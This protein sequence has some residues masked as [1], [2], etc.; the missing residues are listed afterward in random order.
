MNFARPFALRALCLMA[1]LFSLNTSYGRQGNPPGDQIADRLGAK[2]EDLLEFV[3][4]GVQQ[5][6]KQYTS[7]CGEIVETRSSKL[8]RHPLTLRGTFC[9]DGMER[10]RLEY[11]KPD[12]TRLVFNKQF[13]NVT[14][15]EDRKI[16]EILDVGSAVSRTQRYFSRGESLKNLRKNFAIRCQESE[17]AYTLQLLPRSRQFK[18]KLEHMVVVLRKPDFLLQ[19]LEIAGTNGVTSVFQIEI[20]ELNREMDHDVFQVRKP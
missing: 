20:R 5:A 7:G 11:L 9:A 12:S 1:A 17:D 14:A 3:W 19:G 13:L 4:V 10:F 8:L 6:Q 2:E 15:G 18:Q 16:M